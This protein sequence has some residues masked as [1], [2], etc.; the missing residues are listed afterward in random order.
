MISPALS[1]TYVWGRVTRGQGIAGRWFGFPTAN[2]S[3]ATAPTLGF[4][5]YVGWMNGPGLENNPAVICY[6][7]GLTNGVPKFEVHLFDWSGMLE[8]ATVEVA[9]GERISDLVPFEGEDQMRAKIQ[10]DVAEARRLLH[11]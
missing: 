11:L 2:L 1:R 6:G 7:A 9:I 8:G 3:L 4:G 10:S 5:V